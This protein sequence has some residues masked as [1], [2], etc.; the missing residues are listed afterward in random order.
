M[1]SELGQDLQARELEF[2]NDEPVSARSVNIVMGK[3]QFS[4]EHTDGLER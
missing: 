2:P 3:I 4:G 1:D